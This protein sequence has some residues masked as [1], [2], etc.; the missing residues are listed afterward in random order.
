MKKVVPVCVLLVILMM[1]IINA[2][3]PNQNLDDQFNKVNQTTSELV[4]KDPFNKYLSEEIKI[5]SSL[6]KPARI[7]FKLDSNTSVSQLIIIVLLTLL[8]T[9][10]LID[11]MKAF[12]PFSEST[13]IFAGL[14]LTVIMSVSGVL[15]IFTDSFL[16]L[17]GKIRLLE[18]W[19]TGAFSF[20]AFIF[21]MIF[22]IVAR[23]MKEI[24]KMKE[25]NK[26]LEAGAKIGSSIAANDIEREAYSEVSKAAS[27]SSS[28]WWN[29]SNWFKGKKEDLYYSPPKKSWFRKK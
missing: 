5:P 16:S 19:Q 10:M 9:V 12:S 24:R 1:P 2:A 26:K 7:L 15:K 23:I 13:S 8:M 25:K 4:Q 29:P 3:E 20:T 27:S 14:I 22:L 11:I 6:E 17:S 28:K 18:N 21:I